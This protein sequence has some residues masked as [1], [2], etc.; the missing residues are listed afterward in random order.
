[1]CMQV[2][3]DARRGRVIDPLELE[4]WKLWAIQHRCPEPN[5]TPLEEQQVSRLTTEPSLQPLLWKLLR[6]IPDPKCSNWLWWQ[7]VGLSCSVNQ[8]FNLSRALSILVGR[9]TVERME[10]RWLRSKSQTWP[11]LHEQPWNIQ[12][13]A[14]CFSFLAYKTGMVWMVPALQGS[15]RAK[16]SKCIWVTSSD[17]EGAHCSSVF[18]F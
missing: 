4:S 14:P 1:M 2:P 15:V 11:F 18:P 10:I 6:I 17:M 7:S 3:M 13:T 8:L 12:L 9:Y 16:V 5:S